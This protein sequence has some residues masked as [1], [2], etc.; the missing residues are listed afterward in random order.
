MRRALPRPWRG[1]GQEG[2]GCSLTSDLSGEKGTG[3]LRCRG[4]PASTVHSCPLCLLL[5]DLG[6]AESL[7]GLVSHVGE[8]GGLK[9]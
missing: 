3:T 4:Q 9:E 5:G 2:R 6:E 7:Q 1:P 8:V